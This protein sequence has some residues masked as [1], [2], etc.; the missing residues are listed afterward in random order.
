MSEGHLP[1]PERED[2]RLDSVQRFEAML[3]RNDH[4][5]FDVEEF[6]MIIEH[7]LEQSEPRRARQVL[8]YA[9]QQHPASVDLLFCEAQVMTSMGRLN[10]AL[11]VLDKIE[12]LEP[13]NEEV[14][15][16]KAGI[17]GQLRNYRKAIEHYRRA[18]DLAD[19]GLDE[20]Y[21]DLA[22]EHENCEE[23]AEAIE[24]LQQ[25]LDMNPENEAVLYEL[26][27]CF[28]LAD[29]HEASIT[30]F[31][32]FTNDHPYSFVA[33]YNL[34]NALAKRERLEESNQALELCLAI[35]DHFS[36]AHFSLARNL[37]QM[38]RFNDAIACYQETLET[39][40]PQAVTF[41]YIGECYE[42]MEQFEQA[43]I[44]YDQALALD[45]NWVD[46]WIGRGV[47]KD[48]LGRTAE[49]LADLEQAVHVAPDHGD[50]LYYQANILGRAGRYE[51]SLRA[52][53]RLNTQEPENLDGW[54][55]H[56]DLLLVVK[57]PDAALR[58]LREGELVHKLD[59]RYRFRTV[60]YLL[61]D[62]KLQEALL[63]LEEALMADHPAH[64]GLLD[65]YP[66]AAD[67]PQV[68]HLIQLYRQ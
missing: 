22:F 4:Y 24:C 44:H 26:A 17:H 39:D 12:K 58:K 28:D 36:S 37:L 9:R 62:G 11:D 40:G 8:D 5:F 53:E 64:Q 14:H 3:D 41:S 43:L 54:L 49:A 27:Y 67:I 63:Q 18:L 21:L 52:Y 55:D 45:P 13:F 35:E 42:K 31:R 56:A 30:F 16:H 34:G 68:L 48:Q 57:G 38:G 51:E 32:N 59:P 15:L 61:R 23:Y 1:Q 47:V 10:A 7:Y 50:A 2:D 20:I 60:S 46:A 65:H 66:E 33:W 25:A 6:E 29:A 19:E